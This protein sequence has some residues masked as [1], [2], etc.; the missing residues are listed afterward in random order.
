MLAY[1][2]SG[3]CCAIDLCWKCHR[4]TNVDQQIEIY[5][6]RILIRT[7]NG[8]SGGGDGGG[9]GGTSF[10]YNKPLT[11]THPTHIFL[12][13]ACSLFI[14]RY[15]LRAANLMTKCLVWGTSNMR[16]CSIFPKY[17]SALEN[18]TKVKLIGPIRAGLK[19]KFQ[20]SA[21]AATKM[22]IFAVVIPI[23]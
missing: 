4:R 3:R 21:T 5:G 7:V 12:L 2:C 14:H 20:S 16:M 17:S 8:G 13:F 1:V 9:G 18:R 22:I 11:R 10:R 23:Y 15:E 19:S 6:H